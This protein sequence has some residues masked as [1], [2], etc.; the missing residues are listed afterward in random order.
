MSGGQPHQN[1]VYRCGCL[2]SSELSWNLGVKQTT[3]SRGVCWLVLSHNILSYLISC[4]GQ[5][6]KKDSIGQFVKKDRKT[7]QTL[8]TQ[9]SFC[10][11]HARHGQAEI[12]KERSPLWPWQ[13]L[14]LWGWL[15]RCPSLSFRL[16]LLLRCKFQSEEVGPNL[17]DE[18]LL[19]T[20]G[21]QTRYRTAIRYHEGEHDIIDEYNSMASTSKC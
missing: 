14:V 6:V 7:N 2:C 10:F 4:I 13:Y 8:F 21:P 19:D 1:S 12:E 15:W 11:I 9:T 3:G 18:G 16:Q 5:F 20:L 17:K